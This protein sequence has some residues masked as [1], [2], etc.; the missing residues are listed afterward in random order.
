YVSPLGQC[1]PTRFDLDLGTLGGL[2]GSWGPLSLIMKFSDMDKTY[3]KFHKEHYWPFM[4][5]QVYKLCTECSECQKAKHSIHKSKA[6]VYAIETPTKP[7]QS[8]A[9]NFVGLL[10]EV[11][12]SE[13]VMTCICRMTGF[14]FLILLAKKFGAEDC[15]QAFVNHIYPV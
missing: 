1:L 11:E 2:G 12:G 8:L 5:K 6:I 10:P 15:A 14:S 7:F 13:I 9:I 4:W 3:L